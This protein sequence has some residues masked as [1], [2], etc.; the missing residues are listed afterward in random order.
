MLTIGELGARSG[1]AVRTV[2]FYADAN[3]VPVA[4]RSEAGYRLFESDAVARLRLVR[5]LR[6]L[7]VGLDDIRRV[8]AA[9]V[10]LADVAAAHSAALDAQIRTL[11]LQRAVLG[12]VARTTDPQELEQMTDLTTMT[13]QERRRILEE[14]LEAVFGDTA[15]HDPVATKMR[16]GAPDLPEDP[17]PDQVAAWT[18]LVALLRDADFVATSRV[19]AEHATPH[20][21]TQ[22]FALGKAVVEHAG[23]AVRAEVDPAS[24]AAL[25]VVE[26]LEAL[27]P[28]G[29]RDRATVA[30]RIHAFT[31]RRV[32]RYWALVAIVNGWPPAPDTIPAWEWFAAALRAHATVPGTEH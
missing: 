4:G 1:L 7:G 26:Q 29:A 5:T 8:L 28:D 15:T 27:A 18:E 25:T 20:S 9:E 19:M 21:E 16:M 2:R 17:S 30:E 23:A 31:D 32:A 24:P 3:V 6:E 22:S 14:Y 13:T 12:A 11:R 10:A